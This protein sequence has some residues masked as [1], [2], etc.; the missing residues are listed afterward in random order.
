MVLILFNKPYDVLCQFSSSDER[1][2]LADFIDVPDVYPAGRLDADS[3]GL[4][5]LTDSGKLQHQVSHPLHKQ[6]K[7]YM[8]QVE[9]EPTQEQL[10]QLASPIDL[11]DF[12]TLPCVVKH[13]LPPD[14]IWA[15][16]PAVRI[17]KNIPTSWLTISIAEGKN[18]QIR[19]MSA[20]VNLPTLRLIRIGIAGFS[21]E[22][23][24]LMPGE[25][26]Y[27]QEPQLLNK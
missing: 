23:N 4:M 7:T 27:V 1:K 18:R 8:I 13:I 21:L 14:W 25:W 16:T 9:G 22:K 26:I 15:R 3:E 11:G 12:I 2:T 5:L 17:R 20:A 19:R 24:P 6:A 10:L